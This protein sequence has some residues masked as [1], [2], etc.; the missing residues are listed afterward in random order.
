MTDA[1]QIITTTPDK[2]LALRI[3]QALVERRL[4]A[5]VQIFGPVESVYRWQGRVES[6][7]E[8]QCC[9]KTTR[10]RYAE[11]EQAI[12]GL[13]A[14]QVPEILAM[15]VVEGHLDYLGWLAQSVGQQAPGQ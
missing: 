11:V 15:P 9:I 13:H 12:R 6:A 14:Y 8:W 5:C 4:A 1:I 7:T 3:A 2:P 10:D